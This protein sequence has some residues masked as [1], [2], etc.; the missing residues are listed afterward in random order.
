MIASL[1]AVVLLSTYGPPSE[2][3]VIA[4]RLGETM[5]HIHYDSNPHKISIIGLVPEFS[6]IATIFASFAVLAGTRFGAKKLAGRT[7]LS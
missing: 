1:L 2:F 3:V 6:S 5:L 4:G 7:S